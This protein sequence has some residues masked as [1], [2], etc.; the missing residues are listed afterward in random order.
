MEADN[1]LF[2]LMV[3]GDNPDEIIKKYDS[4]LEVEP[5]IKYYYKDIS[6]YRK[7]AIKVV[8]ELLFN[9][10]KLSLSQAVKDYFEEKAKVLEKMSD[11]EYYTSISDGCSYDQDGNAL[12]TENPN[13]KWSTCRIGRNLCIPL[14]LKNGTDVLQAKAGDVDWEKMHMVGVDVYTAAWQLFHKEREPK[15]VQEKEIYENIKNQKRYFAGF[16]CQEDYVNY[17]CSYW[18]YAYADKD[19]WQDADDHKDYKWITSFYDKFVK[20]LKPDDMVT[21]YECSKP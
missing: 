18:C 4:A 20:K 21:I 9:T 14:R 13:G 7:K 5:Y 8:Q 3:V 12:T 15:T 10:D 1:K 11:F 6:K 17:C 16:D 19:G 2:T